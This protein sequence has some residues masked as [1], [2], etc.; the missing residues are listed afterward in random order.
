MKT[1]AQIIDLSEDFFD[2]TGSISD[3]EMEYSKDETPE[4][5]P[6]ITTTSDSNPDEKPLKIDLTRSHEKKQRRV[7]F[8]LTDL[9]DSDYV[10]PPDSRT[11]KGFKNLKRTTDECKH[12]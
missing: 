2:L 5:L 6:A 10:T 4:N 11:S 8:N 9:K 12:L 1:P 3:K 7:E